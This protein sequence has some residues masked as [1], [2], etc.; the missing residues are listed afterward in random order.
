MARCYVNSTS[1][2]QLR[3]LFKN[4]IKY[5][6]KNR[7]SR[8]NDHTFSVKGNVNEHTIV[9]SEGR[10]VCDCDLFKGTGSFE[11]N[12]GECSHSQTVKLLTS[13]PKTS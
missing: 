9:Y 11:G 13:I 1:F 3:K 4:T 6:A 2:I 8:V 12:P 10:W 5:L 7:V